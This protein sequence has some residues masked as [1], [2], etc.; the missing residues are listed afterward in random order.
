[1]TPGASRAET[2]P[3]GVGQGYMREQ[4]ENAS[5]ISDDDDSMAAV[6]RQS[7]STSPVASWL[8]SL[9]RRG[10]LRITKEVSQCENSLKLRLPLTLMSV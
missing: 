4:L 7:G 8:T 5:V 10:L 6:C 9:A 2:P 3:F 1:M